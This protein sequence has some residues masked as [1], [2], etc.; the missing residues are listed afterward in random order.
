MPGAAVST[1]GL[2]GVGRPRPLSREFALLAYTGSGDE[3]TDVL[4]HLTGFL[5]GFLLGWLNGELRGDW[6]F[7]PDIQRMAGGVALAIVASCWVI[8]FA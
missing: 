3:N 8:A 4:A 5:C 2:A 7:R 6:R 1:A